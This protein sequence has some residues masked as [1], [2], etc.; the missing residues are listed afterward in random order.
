MNRLKTLSIRWN[1]LCWSS[2][3]LGK[4]FTFEKGEK[5]KSQYMISQY[6]TYHNIVI[7]SYHNLSIVI[8]YRDFSIVIIYR[9]F[10]IVIIYRDSSI[11]IIS[12][13]GAS[14]DSQPYPICMATKLFEAEESKLWKSESSKWT[15]HSFCKCMKKWSKITWLP[16]CLYF[17]LR[18]K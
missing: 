3:T 2:F 7:I 10:S 12:Y 13:R 9:D 4:C 11:V 15:N 16:F 8:I 6:S 18:S 17:F 14:G 1:R 5:K